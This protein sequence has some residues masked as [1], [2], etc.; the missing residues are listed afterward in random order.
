MYSPF[1]K[2]F[3]Q[4]RSGANKIYQCAICLMISA[5]VLLVLRVFRIFDILKV[6]YIPP[7]KQN[8]VDQGV[9]KKDQR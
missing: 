9:L 6:V 2:E 4:I 3:P 8:H 5:Y 1:L 7:R